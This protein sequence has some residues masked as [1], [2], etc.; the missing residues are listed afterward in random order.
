MKPVFQV[1]FALII[2]AALGALILSFSLDRIVKSNIES[3][4][5][6][7][8]DTSV[9]VN[10][11]SISI[12]DGTGTIDG[13]TIHNPDGY[14]DKPAVKLQQISMAVD[15]SSL[16]SDTVVVKEVR[17]Q[18]P[19]LYFE[20]KAGGNNLNALTEKLK[21]QPSSETSMVI[22]Y[23]LVADGQVTLTAD[24]GKEKTVK[25]EFSKIKIEG[26]GRQ[27]NN[28]ME[29]AMQQILEPILQRAL[30]EAV[31]QGLMDKA[32]DALQNIL[33]GN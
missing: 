12:L 9:Q 24:I 5:S 19:E 33:D 15:L 3:T 23:L 1:L 16:L 10:N 30:Q 14:S 25:G 28:T 32:K 7:M 4:T 17:I 21:T 22:D 31:E 8:L 13:I 18:K 2:I 26:I 29:Q 20:Q 27:G 11:V 6:E